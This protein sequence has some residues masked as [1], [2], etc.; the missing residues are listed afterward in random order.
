MWCD[1]LPPACPAGTIAGI[2]NGCAVRGRSEHKEG[3]AWDW[4]VSAHDRADAAR[5]SA[6]LNWLL[7]K[8][9]RGKKYGNARRL[10]IMYIIWNRRIWGSAHAKDGWRPY[11][12]AHP[13][14]DHVHFSF[15]WAGAMRRTSFWTGKVAK[16][17]YGPCPRKGGLAPKYNGPNSKRCRDETGDRDRTRARK[18]N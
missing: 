10:G 12:G 17:D 15:G 18:D 9:A 4:A 8:D 3:R 5:A 2:T 7:K 11:T 14:T 13:H 1:A 16:T 6:L